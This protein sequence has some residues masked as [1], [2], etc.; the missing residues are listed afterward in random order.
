MLT[1]HN[2]FNIRANMHISF[3]AIAKV[4]KTEIEK[5]GGNWLKCVETSRIGSWRT[6]KIDNWGDWD[7]DYGRGYL[8]NLR[9][10]CQDVYNWKFDYDEGNTSLG[11]HASFTIKVYNGQYALDAAWDA[12]H[13][14]GAIWGATCEWAVGVP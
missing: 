10:H 3:L 12:S 4:K 9:G 11:G 1:N 14:T 8:D 2:P 5:R 6:Y 7:D 13:P